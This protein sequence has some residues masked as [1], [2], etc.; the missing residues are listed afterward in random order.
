METLQIPSNITILG[1]GVTFKQIG[2]TIN[3]P[4]FY[5]EQSSN[6]RL[7]GINF[8]GN[9]LNVSGDNSHGVVLIGC[10]NIILE[11]LKYT[12][13]RKIAIFCG[14]FEGQITKNVSIDNCIATNLGIELENIRGSF[15][16]VFFCKEI[17]I[18]NIIVSNCHGEFILAIKTIN[19]KITNFDFSNNTIDDGVSLQGCE[20]IIISNGIIEEMLGCG[21]EIQGCTNFDIDNIKITNCIRYGILISTYLSEYI[22]APPSCYGNISKTK[23]YIG[24][25]SSNYSDILI[26]GSHHISIHEIITSFRVTIAETI[27][28]IGTLNSEYIFVENS[29]L[30]NL[31]LRYTRNLELK[32]NIIANIT[33]LES[34]YALLKDLNQYDLFFKTNLGINTPYNIAV[35]DLPVIAVVPPNNMN[36]CSFVNGIVI[37]DNGFSGDPVVQFTTKMY[38][39]RS[40]I[41]NTSTPWQSNLLSTLNGSTAIRDFSVSF[42]D[43]KIIVTNISGVDTIVRVTV[44]SMFDTWG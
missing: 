32:G 12:D 17:S 38:H 29:S 30:N 31:N 20:N 6:I 4:I 15:I 5:I 33:N 44:K 40:E 23:I 11:N 19:L 22:Y 1:N 34:S 28:A 39:V 24:D 37:I 42:V 16:N 25:P 13:I 35:F 26:A 10:E 18:N 14:D 43:N 2:G 41:T 36:N 21:I 9:K 3:T 7:N 27:L 8:D